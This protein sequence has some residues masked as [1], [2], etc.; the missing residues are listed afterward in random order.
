MEEE[1]GKDGKKDTTPMKKPSAS[2]PTKKTTPMKRPAAAVKTPPK[3][4]KV[5]A[6]KYKDTNTFGYK[7]NGKQVLTATWIARSSCKQ[8]MFK[9]G[10]SCPTQMF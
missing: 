9:L 8:S 7:V 3:K 1:K 10:S 5:G 6:Y 4:V 2:T